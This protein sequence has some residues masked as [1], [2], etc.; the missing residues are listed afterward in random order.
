MQNEKV[1]Q[2]TTMG[3]VFYSIDRTNLLFIV[4]TIFVAG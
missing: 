3:S 4:F 1:K 2:L